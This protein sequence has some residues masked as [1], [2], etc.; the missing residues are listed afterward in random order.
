MLRSIS[1]ESLTYYPKEDITKYKS[2]LFWDIQPF[3]RRID[4]VCMPGS[5]SEVNI[6]VYNGCRHRIILYTAMKN[7]SRGRAYALPKDTFQTG[8]DSVRVFRWP[9]DTLNADA[10]YWE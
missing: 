8:F 1:L 7:N 5:T 9:S 10:F 3:D 6:L 2:R 4:T